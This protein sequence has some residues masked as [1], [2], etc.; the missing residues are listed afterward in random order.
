MDATVLVLVEVDMEVEDEPLD[1]G[2]EFNEGI[3][4]GVISGVLKTVGDASTSD[5]GSHVDVHIAVTG[6]LV[7]TVRSASGNKGSSGDISSKR[8]KIELMFSGSVRS[9]GSKGDVDPGTTVAVWQVCDEAS[10]V[11]L[12]ERE[13]TDGSAPGTRS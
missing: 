6:S 10:K 12:D 11:S 8:S 3:M 2:A 1:E 13:S 7:D 5:C 4:A 9:V